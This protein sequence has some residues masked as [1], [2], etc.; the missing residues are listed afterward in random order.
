MN[1]RNLLIPLLCLGAVAFAISLGGF[2]T[3]GRR[4]IAR[5]RAEF[6]AVFPRPDA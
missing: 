4:T 6:S 1:V 5:G 3:W 2:V